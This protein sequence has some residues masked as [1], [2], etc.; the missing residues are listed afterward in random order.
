MMVAWVPDGEKMWEEPALVNWGR[1]IIE[2]G[3]LSD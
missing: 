2:S 3:L 1:R